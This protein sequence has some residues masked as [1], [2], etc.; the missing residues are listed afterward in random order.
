MMSVTHNLSSSVAHKLSAL[1]ITAEVIVNAENK[2]V[3][4]D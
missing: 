3:T 2:S 1:E 4:G